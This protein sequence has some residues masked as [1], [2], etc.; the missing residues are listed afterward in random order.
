MGVYSREKMDNFFLLLVFLRRPLEQTEATL[1]QLARFRALLGA[2]A[3]ALDRKKAPFLRLI[4][5]SRPFSSVSPSFLTFTCVSITGSVGSLNPRSLG[6]FVCASRIFL[7]PKMRKTLS[8]R[9]GSV[10][11]SCLLNWRISNASRGPRQ[12]YETRSEARDMT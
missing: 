6:R 7:S 12:G 9:D 10:S 4:F 2:L 5:S 3:G 1:G 8:K 11:N